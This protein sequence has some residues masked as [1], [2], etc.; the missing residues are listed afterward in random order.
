MQMGMG[1]VCFPVALSSLALRGGG[2]E[3]AGMFRRESLVHLAVPFE[4]TSHSKLLGSQLL[5][6][7]VPASVYPPRKA[8]T[9][10]GWDLEGGEGSGIL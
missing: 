5:L 9:K 4:D 10:G 2:E 1:I 6:E 7:G 8:E 3:L